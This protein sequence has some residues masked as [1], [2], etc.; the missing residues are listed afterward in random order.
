[1]VFSSFSFL[2]IFFPA[3]CLCYFLVPG[4]FRSAR[5]L[6]LLAFS[7]FFYFWGEAKGV[8]LMLAV[9]AVSFGS[10][11]LMGDTT[12]ERWRR[13]LGL[14]LEL[15]V[16]LGVL[17]YFKYTGLLVRTVNSLLVLD[18]KVPEIVMPIGISFFTFQSMSYVFDVYRGKV[19]PQRNP[20]HVALYV[21]LFPQLVAG[22]IV[23][24]ETV[25]EEITNRRETPE[26]VYE[27][28]QRF[29]M[30]FGKK[31]LLANAFGREAEE[32]FA[33]S[34]AQ[35]GTPAA[36]LGVAL[37]G[38]QIYFDFSA[39][40]DMAIGMGRMFGFHF[41]ENF[42]YPYTARSVSEFW[43][44]WHMS[45]STWFRDYIYIPLGGN[46]KGLARQLLNVF[47]VWAL[48]GLWHGASWNY[49]LWGVYFGI[50][51]MLEKLFLGKLLQKLPRA[52]GHLYTLLAGT[53]AWTLFYFP[54]MDQVAQYWP[55]L[56]RFQGSFNH[57]LLTLRQH[58]PELVFG[59]A[60]CTSLPMRLFRMS[61]GKPWAELLRCLWLL[62]V[63]ALSV[64]ALTGSSFNAFIYFRF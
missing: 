28:L 49:V 34:P 32:I 57:V 54:D 26:D 39:Y 12:T 17:V 56:F 48:T 20:L 19:P 35:R 61:A 5:N 46:R 52:V 33:M 21:A 31:L 51:L 23:R 3:V 9:I 59:L 55:E 27:G 45:L 60:L 2:L 44:R 1:M 53:L 43:R 10:A 58:V 6:V 47:I 29:I 36:W 18:L 50:L 37:Y 16:C 30:G 38:L 25:A 62:G 41:P 11:L 13:R 8:L 4:R 63:L 40:S 22:P 14:W 42:N 24:Y 15:L 7:L 64:L